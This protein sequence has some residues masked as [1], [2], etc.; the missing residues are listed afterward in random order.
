METYVQ[1]T[2]NDDTSDVV[3]LHM[4]CNDIFNKCMSEEDTVERIV[5]IDRCCTE[6]NVNNDIISS[7]ICK[8]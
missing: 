5:N 4:E 6:Q 7:L 1:P 3:I 8:T 2:I